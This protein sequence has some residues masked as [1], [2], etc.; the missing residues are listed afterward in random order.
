MTWRAKRPRRACL[1]SRA[2]SSKLKNDAYIYVHKWIGIAV[3]CSG[4]TGNS[5]LSCFNWNAKP[6]L[7]PITVYKMWKQ[8]WAT[9]QEYRSVAE[10]CGDR[11]KKAEAQIEWKLVRNVKSGH[12]RNHSIGISTTKG[13]WRTWWCCCSVGWVTLWWRHGKGWGTQCPLCFSLY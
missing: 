9:W 3:G 1:S 4:W 11:G 6:P 5:R 12:T 7:P 8:E 13:K 10:E 2:A